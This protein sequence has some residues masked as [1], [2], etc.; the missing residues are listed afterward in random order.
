MIA[1]R[2]RSAVTCPSDDPYRRAGSNSSTWPNNSNN[3]RTNRRATAT[4][5][6]VVLMVDKAHSQMNP[7]G[8]VITPCPVPRVWS[9]MSE[10]TIIG[11]VNLIIMI[12]LITADRS[13]KPNQSITYLLPRIDHH[14]C[15]RFDIAQQ[16]PMKK[17]AVRLHY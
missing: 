16:R 4:S 8:V 17:L 15:P 1:M 14:H 2:S 9:G 11:T 7:Q 13:Q 5:I 6:P 10:R 12:P 3:H